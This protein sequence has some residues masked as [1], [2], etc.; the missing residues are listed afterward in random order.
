MAVKRFFFVAPKRG[1]ISH[2]ARSITEGTRTYCGRM[3]QL[4]TWCWARSGPA[5]RH[6]K[7]VVCKTCLRRIGT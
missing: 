3:V 2:M 7:R 1:R 5:K 4:G 6:A